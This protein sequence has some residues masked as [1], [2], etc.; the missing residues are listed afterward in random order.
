M[1]I[2]ERIK[3]ARKKAG[4]KQSELAEKLG[5]AV[6]T[7]GQYE[8]G[9]RQPR[10]EQFQRI[11]VVLDVDVNWLMNGQTLEQRDQAMKDYVA[12]RFAEAEAGLQKE[13]REQLN[14][15]FDRLNQDG[16][17]KAV[18]RVEELTEIP[19]YRRTTTTQSTPA[20]PE[21][22]DTAKPSAARETP[23]EGK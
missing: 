11:A 16:Q 20:P 5:V 18:E 14:A 13:R 12:Q 2:G 4:L 17:G 6:I 10:L 21:G 3:E 19:K 1:S 9:I 7:I 8:R 22:K 23:P 15:A